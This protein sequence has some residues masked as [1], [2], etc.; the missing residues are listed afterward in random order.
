MPSGG[1]ALI[2]TRLQT[3]STLKEVFPRDLT[4]R[5]I[6]SRGI[7]VNTNP[8]LLLDSSLL[9]C[10]SIISQALR[11]AMV[12]AEVPLRGKLRAEATII[13]THPL[14][15]QVPLP[16]LACTVCTGK[17]NN[18]AAPNCPVLNPWGILYMQTTRVLLGACVRPRIRR[19]ALRTP[20]LDP[21]AST[22]SA[23]RAVRS[24]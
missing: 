18:L 22:F 10:P 21:R 17:S 23:L 19:R 20:S 1:C 15:P 24:H 9:C 2:G 13:S 14:I 12:A 4:C 7:S 6:P 8:W 11:A 5:D 3:R 16:M